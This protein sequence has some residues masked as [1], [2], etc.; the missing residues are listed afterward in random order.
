MS[1]LDAPAAESAEPVE[2]GH[3]FALANADLIIRSSDLVDFR[4]YKTT[5]AQASPIFED[6]LS[7]LPASSWNPTIKLDGTKDGLPVIRLPERRDV[8]YP[9]L[10]SIFPVTV[11]MPESF[12]D[13]APVLGAAQRYQM[14]SGLAILRLF[15]NARAE[16][17]IAE[18]NAFEAYC[19]ACYHGLTEDASKA[20]SFI[21]VN[22]PVM[23]DLSADLKLLT[24]PSL[25]ALWD[26]HI[27]TLEAA[28]A[29]LQAF[30]SWQSVFVNAQ[31]KCS[32]LDVD[33]VTP[34]WLIMCSREMAA[35][36]HTFS[37]FRM[38][39]SQHSVSSQCLVCLNIPVKSLKAIYEEIMQ[40][41]VASTR[42]SRFPFVESH[43][44]APPPVIPP[45]PTDFGAPFDRR[46][47]DII[48]RSSD[49]VDFR[50]HKSIISVASNIFTDMLSFPQHLT[51]DA[52]SLDVVKDGLPVVNL[53]EDATTLH[54]LL[55][56]VYP[57]EKVFPKTFEEAAPLLSLCQK[58]EM[59][60][61]S[62]LIRA[63]CTNS[64][65]LID[66]YIHNPFHS[67]ALATRNYLY[68][69]TQSAARLTL[70][71]PMSWA[72]YGNDLHLV[73]GAALYHLVQYRQKCQSAI[74]DCIIRVLESDSPSLVPTFATL[75]EPRCRDSVVI[76][77]PPARFVTVPTWW[78]VHFRALAEDVRSGRVS[79]VPA[80]GALRA[81]LRVAIDKHAV[82]LGFM[83][84]TFCHSGRCVDLGNTFLKTLTKQIEKAIET[85]KITT[86]W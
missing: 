69:E 14:H 34:T 40:R 49:F 7:H 16:S 66:I 51:T 56:F 2:F 81:A 84:C 31:N 61:T 68:D 80:P 39:R 46:D 72:E 38:E 58:Y 64:T 35:G 19:L 74:S 54:R 28:R 67:Y 11:Y 10:T 37:D 1:N 85:I 29:G 43:E 82:Q 26:Y 48:V 32:A 79:P 50:L 73:T 47:A 59:A 55:S 65:Q 24:G 12:R 36:T 20:A 77:Y 33:G 62:G 27:R 4:V 71:R 57:V 41:I 75:G 15:A 86:E 53:P 63:A 9:L 3:P 45:S 6:V 18:P 21:A 22:L 17:L 83:A 8:I 76:A 13:L 70:A 44:Q 5:L 25:A 23:D 60:A 42:S 78:N 30:T 52:G